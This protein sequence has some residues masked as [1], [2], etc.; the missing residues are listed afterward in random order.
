MKFRILVAFLAPY[1]FSIPS[2]AQ[3]ADAVLGIWQSE[4]GSARVQISKSGENYNGKIT[5]LKEEDT[6]SGKPKTDQNN[7]SEKLRSQL[8]LGL[9]ALSDFSYKGDGVWEGGT[10]YDPRTGKKYS[11]RLSI[12]GG[13]KLEIRAYMGI[14]LIGKTQIWSRVK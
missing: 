10:V 8:I 5:W 13:G 12:A 11:G 6:E 9:E 2:M 3:N 4:H 7:P 14:S 1:L